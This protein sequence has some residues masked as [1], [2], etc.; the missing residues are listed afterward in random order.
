MIKGAETRQPIFSC[1]LN[2]I[3]RVLTKGKRDP[4]ESVRDSDEVDAEVG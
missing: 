4:R 1:G 2:V 3:T